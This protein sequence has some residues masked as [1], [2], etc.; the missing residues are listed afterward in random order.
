MD[1][2]RKDDTIVEGTMSRLL[3]FQGVEIAKEGGVERRSEGAEILRA[4]K[5]EL[6]DF[7][8]AVRVFDDGAEKA[9]KQ[10]TVKPV[11]APE[12][13]PFAVKPRAS[14]ARQTTLAVLVPI[15]SIVLLVVLN[16]FYNVPFLQSEWLRLG[17]YRVMIADFLD[18]GAVATDE[19]GQRPVGLKV[20][21]VALSHDRPSAVIGTTIVHEGDTVLGATVARI[22]RAGVEFEVNGETWTQKVQ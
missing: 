1:D 10:K 9:P 18:S 12:G 7:A 20:R 8:G 14:S 16:K 13:G 22:S 15:L 17:T 5:K 11:A 2:R 6:L 19:G 4:P 3:G 21:G